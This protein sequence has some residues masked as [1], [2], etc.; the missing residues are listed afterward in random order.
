[1]KKAEGGCTPS[2]SVTL[3]LF[4]QLQCRHSR[5]DTAT[6]PNGVILHAL[7]PRVNSARVARCIGAALHL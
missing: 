3:E 7:P 2:A 1:M 5:P 6:V 4:E